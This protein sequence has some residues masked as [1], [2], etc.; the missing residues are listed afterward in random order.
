MRSSRGTSRLPGSSLVPAP[1][2]WRY[3][4]YADDV[5]ALVE[6]ADQAARPSRFRLD[7][8]RKDLTR[9]GLPP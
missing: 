6:Q 5:A 3:N 2:R 8:R 4:R 7:G 9:A 1:A